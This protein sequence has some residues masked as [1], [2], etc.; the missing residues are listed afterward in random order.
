MTDI[1]WLPFL[2]V[3]LLAYAIPGP[4]FAVVARRQ[5]AAVVP[6]GERASARRPDCACT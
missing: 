6:G 3:V 2:G 1:Q 4:D 5:R